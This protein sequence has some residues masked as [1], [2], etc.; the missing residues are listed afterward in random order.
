MKRIDKATAVKVILFAL[1]WL[2]VLLVREGYNP[3]PIIDETTAALI[4]T[5]AI[6]LYTTVTHVFL[7]KRGQAQKKQ[8]EKTGLK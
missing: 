7:G 2:N 8:L 4:V 5:F 1:T 6:S 3:L